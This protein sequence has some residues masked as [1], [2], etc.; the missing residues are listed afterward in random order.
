M[1]IG[2][3]RILMLYS[4]PASNALICLTKCSTY[5]ISVGE[6]TPQAWWFWGGQCRQDIRE[7]VE[8]S[9]DPE[10][11]IIV[12]SWWTVLQM[13]QCSS[14]KCVWGVRCVN[15]CIH[16]GK[17]KHENQWQVTVFLIYILLNPKIICIVGLSLPLILQW[18]WGCMLGFMF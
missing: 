9:A 14:W 3:L 12:N 17:I 2:S 18:F 5:I 16:L 6:R 11:C 13:I 15:D 1:Y 10:I 4:L 8:G 7:H